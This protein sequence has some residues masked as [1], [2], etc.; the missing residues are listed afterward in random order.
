MMQEQMQ[1][2]LDGYVAVFEAAKARTGSDEVAAMIVEQLGKDSRTAI[3]QNGRGNGA[4]KPTVVDRDGAA[5]PK[6]VGLL[7]RLG[8]KEFPAGLTKAAASS[9]IDQLQ[10]RR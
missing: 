10:E 5:T 6:Q 2:K 7:R 8:A 4:A 3:L 9:W 1:T